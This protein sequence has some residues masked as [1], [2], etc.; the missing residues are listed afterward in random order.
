MYDK[1]FD[2]INMDNMGEGLPPYDIP[3]L[4]GPNQQPN[5][6]EQE[7]LADLDVSPEVLEANIQSQNPDAEGQIFDAVSDGNAQYVED[8]PPELNDDVPSDV[9]S[10][11]PQS[12]KPNASAFIIFLVLGIVAIVGALGFIYSDEISLMVSKALVT[13]QKAE[14][15]SAQ[16]QNLPSGLPPVENDGAVSETDEMTDEISIERKKLLGQDI[17]QMPESPVVGEQNLPVLP[18]AMNPQNVP[19]QMQNNMPTQ[20]SVYIPMSSGT[21][22]R[23]DPFNPSYGS[24]SSLEVLLPPTNPTP[25]PTAQQLM[26]LK[27]SGIMY[28]ADSPSAIINVDG[29]DQLVRRGDKFNGF[30]V[31]RITQ[32]KVTVRNGNNTYT[33]S[34]GQEINPKNVGVNAIP[35]LNRKFAGPYSKGGRIIEIN[36]LN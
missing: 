10:A 23:L 28:T 26:G 24:N 29:S 34:V 36:T 1:D 4:S 18:G 17:A 35:N 13:V 27:I 11:R 21:F 9:I 2:D 8:L 30:V 25:D 7:I 33:A 5:S 12:A 6:I 22:G 20:P 3:E 15:S 19:P 14:D 31:E 32:D 16:E